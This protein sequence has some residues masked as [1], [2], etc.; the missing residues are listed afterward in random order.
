MDAF[1]AIMKWIEPA[2]IKAGGDGELW[3]NGMAPETWFLRSDAN[4]VFDDKIFKPES[5]EFINVDDQHYFNNPGVYLIVDNTVK[6]PYGPKELMRLE[7]H[8]YPEGTGVVWVMQPH[9]NPFP[10]TG[11]IADQV[12]LWKLDGTSGRNDFA[13]QIERNPS[14][15]DIYR[16]MEY[17]GESFRPLNWTSFPMTLIEKI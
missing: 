9:I 13:S 10:E 4:P 11:I 1:Q 7:I 15:W 6:K 5:Y 8:D 12:Q 2:S 17:M 3:Q 16:L 14:H